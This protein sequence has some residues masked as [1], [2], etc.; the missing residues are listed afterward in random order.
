MNIY[1]GI[2]NVKNINVF[3]ISFTSSNKLKKKITFNSA[4]ILQEIKISPLTVSKKYTC[5]FITHTLTP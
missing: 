3:S 2:F 4:G 5:K 1:V